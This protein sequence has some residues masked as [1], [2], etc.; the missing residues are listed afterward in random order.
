MK[1]ICIMPV[2]NE[3]WC[4]DL[5]ARAA[6][7][8]CDWLIVLDHA[9]TDLSSAM[10][11]NLMADDPRVTY[12]TDSDPQWNEMAHRQRLL[13]TARQHDATHIAT[14]DADEVLT[15]NFLVMP[16]QEWGTTVNWIK[17]AI[18]QMPSGSVMQLPWV[19]LRGSIHR[20]H[21]TGVWAEQFVSTAF[22]DSPE[23]HWAA[24]NGY[25]FHHRHPMGREC[26][27]YRPIPRGGGGLMHLQMVSA[28]RLKAKQALY[29]MQE[30]IR[31]PGRTSVDEIDRM[32][33]L[34]VHG[35]LPQARN[36]VPAWA[37]K[38]ARRAGEAPE[39][40][41]PFAPVPDA[42][43]A[44]YA[45]L[46]KYLDVD[47]EPWQEKEAQR[48]MKEHGPMKFRGLDLFGVCG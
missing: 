31:W 14:V 1:L 38:N 13:E 17:P 35:D 43:W 19:Q 48:M 37:P 8:W 7:M 29:K 3:S 23:L 46:M 20:M 6:L 30:V 21:N 12:L 18:E 15:G 10:I 39:S 32:Y 41:D 44:P 36:G 26:V 2:R 27:P 16:V 9:S 42:W 40:V 33:S 24:R 4:L 28:R 45:H 5:T 11:G 22:Q 47:A 34:A 25:D